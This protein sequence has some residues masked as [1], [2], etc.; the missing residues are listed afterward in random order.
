MTDEDWIK[1]IEAQVAAHMHANGGPTSSPSITV[2]AEILKKL[3]GHAFDGLKKRAARVD[4]G[5]QDAPIFS[6]K[7]KAPVSYINSVTS[8]LSKDGH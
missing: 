2:N 5:Q 6:D 1:N 8:K 3:I 7:P 4:V